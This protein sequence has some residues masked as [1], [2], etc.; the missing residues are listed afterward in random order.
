MPNTPLYQ[1]FKPF[2]R[3]LAEASG[4]VLEKYFRSD[5]LGLEVKSDDTPVTRADREAEMVLREL[6]EKRY[7]DH[8]IIGEEYGEENTDAEFVW[9][10]DP[11]DGTKSYAAG[12]P[13]YGTLLC[14]MH[15]NKPVLGAIHQPGQGI[16]LVGD[17]QETELNG[18]PVRV[19]D[20][21]D[22]SQAILLTTDPVSPLHTKYGAAWQDLALQVRLYRSWGDCWGYYMVASGRAHIM[23]DLGLSD[24]DKLS[25]IPII[26]GAGGVIT[27]WEGEDP[28]LGSSVLAT[29]PGLHRTVLELLH[30]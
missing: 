29:V 13:L 25:L 5:D 9:V 16:F 8:G 14:L 21:S 10:L 19:R 2:F 20:C 30:R 6:I 22:L 27:T 18:K 4:A 3:E 11:I 26:K 28:Q 17:G 23:A 7:P 12:I 15:E 24:W 1:T